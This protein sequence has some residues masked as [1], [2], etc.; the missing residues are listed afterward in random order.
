MY[1]A[2]IPGG[3]CTL[4]CTHQLG[5]TVPFS[6]VALWVFLTS[7]PTRGG[8]LYPA[9]LPGGSKT[10]QT[11]QASSIHLVKQLVHVFTKLQHEPNDSND[12]TLSNPE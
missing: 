6:L 2:P 12:S 3:S 7:D 5:L 4:G 10:G 8:Y 11:L 9:P 1:P